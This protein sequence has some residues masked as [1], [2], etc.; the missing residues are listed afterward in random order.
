MAIAWW[1]DT[2]IYSR[3]ENHVGQNQN[4]TTEWTQP[5]TNEKESLKLSHVLPLLIIFGA[6]IMT[7]MIVFGLEL[8]I[9]RVKRIKES[10]TSAKRHPKTGI[11]Q[12]F[13][14]I[15]MANSMP[16]IV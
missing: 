7:S 10:R 1:L 5:T 6:A 15:N 12:P 2:G 9:R 14:Q 16:K 8:L 3:M 4:W 11:T 13:H